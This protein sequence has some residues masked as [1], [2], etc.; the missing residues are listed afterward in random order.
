MGP[1][2]VL[3]RGPIKKKIYWKFAVFVRV[4]SPSLSFC[5]CIQLTVYVKIQV[6]KKKDFDPLN[7]NNTMI[8]LVTARFSNAIFCT[9]DK[10]NICYQRWYCINRS[11]NLDNSLS[12][13]EQSRAL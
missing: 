13:T 6:L 9:R 10:K 5:M 7:L 3:A 1:P 8:S 2:I 11:T 12:L 4:I